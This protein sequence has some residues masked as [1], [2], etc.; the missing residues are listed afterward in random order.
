MALPDWHL[1]RV[2]ALSLLWILAAF[3]YRVV[4]SIAFAREVQAQ[5]PTADI[6]VALIHL[7]GGLWTF[8]GPPALLVMAWLALRRSRPTANVA[9]QLTTLVSRSRAAELER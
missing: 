5:H 2:V 8:L 4:R 1:R 9:V 3:G 6:Y 7:P